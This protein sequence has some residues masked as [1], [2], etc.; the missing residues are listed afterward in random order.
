MND[1]T[2]ETKLLTHVEEMGPVKFS[3]L[4]STVAR[5]CRVPLQKVEWAIRGLLQRQDLTHD[6]EHRI[7]R[8]TH[9]HSRSALRALA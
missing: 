5:E 7:I 3:P 1:K 2:I 8:S 6:A 4:A 9:G